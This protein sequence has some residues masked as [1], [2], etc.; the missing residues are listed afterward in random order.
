MPPGETLAARGSES[1]AEVDELAQRIR[2]AIRELPDRPQA[3]IVLRDIEGLSY[4][5]M[6]VILETSAP[7]ARVLVHRV[8]ETVRQ[9]LLTRWPD[10]FGEP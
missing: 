10:T 5:Q 6:A 1:P 2:Q 9:M 4:D 8:R 7:T 3:A